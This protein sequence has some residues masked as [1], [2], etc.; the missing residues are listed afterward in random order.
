MADTE[1]TNTPATPEKPAETP[2]GADFDPE[3][4][5][6][7][8]QNLRTERDALK[9]ERDTLKSKS[10]ALEDDGKTELQKLQDRAEAAEKAAK[11]AARELS[12]Q[13]VLRKHPELEDFADL[14]SG[15]N[16][17]EIA[18]KAER[19]AAIGKPKEPADP[20]A[21][22]PAGEQ[23]PAGEPELPGKPT[24]S[25]TPG[26]GGEEN[27]PFDPVAIAKAARRN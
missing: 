7:L 16:E 20:P 12:V 26:H 15:D 14:L 18:A 24:P 4:A 13:K 23:P 17:E 27:A 11:E 6:K 10:Q 3:R 25:L 21:D 5:W 22:P 9:T 19:L 1:N 8:V 2:W